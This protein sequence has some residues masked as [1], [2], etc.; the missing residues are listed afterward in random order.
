MTD[1]SSVPSIPGVKAPP[2]VAHTLRQQV[3]RLLQ[4]NAY[5][6]P[7]AQP[8]SFAKRHIVENLAAEDYFVCEKSDGIRCIM[9]MTTFN[10]A[11][12]VYLID[13]K[14]DYYYVQNL[15]FPL[16]EDISRFHTDCL[17][18]GE[19]V[20]DDYGN[21]KKVMKFLVFDS[22]VIDGKLLV[23][24]TLDKRLGY[25][26]ELVYKPYEQLC[27][28]YPHEVEFFPFV[29]GFKDMEFSYALTKLWDEIVPNLKHGCDG[30]IFTSRLMPYV[31][32]SDEKILKWKPPDENS[33]D[34][35]M[36]LHFPIYTPGAAD[37]DYET[38][39]EDFRQ[40]R[41]ADD[42]DD[43]DE[44]YIDYDSQPTTYLSV[45]CGGDNY[46]PFAE[47]QL[48]PEEWDKMKAR[49][50]P[51]DHRIV[52]CVMDRDNNTWH[53]MR[54]R[55][56]KLHPNH[57]SVVEKIVESIRDGV[58]KEELLASKDRIRDEWKRRQR[59]SAAGQG[60]PRPPDAAVPA[61][62]RTGE[63]RKLQG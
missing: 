13:R 5:S 51:L 9:Y 2:D 47:L 37:D 32:G 19:L 27:K 35:R 43:N 53:F 44:P 20:M 16:A 46:K 12:A 36:T 48:T 3:A 50:E 7:G 52:E 6:F 10:G 39:D 14:N 61:H 17:V 23:Q 25:F 62:A 1:G 21:G 57:I 59:G 18:D 31:F 11:E 58:T 22:L 4:R 40:P 41:A 29:V 60:R 33:I 56:D 26:R 45:W 24:R 55:D 63:K 49:N 34:F 42:Q 38:E 30:L 28:S 8:V 54:F 15:H